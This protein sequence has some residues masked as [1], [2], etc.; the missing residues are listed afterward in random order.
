MRNQYDIIISGAGMVG[1]TLACALG[2]SGL[3]V[4]VIDRCDACFRYTSPPGQAL[5]A[6]HRDID[7]CALLPHAPLNPTL[8]QLKVYES[9]APRADDP[10]F[11]INGDQPIDV[12]NDQIDDLV[13]DTLVGEAVGVLDRPVGINDQDVLRTDMRANPPGLEL[14]RFAFEQLAVVIGGWRE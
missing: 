4:A 14:P 8:E 6:Q 7:L 3:K 5:G 9:L 12:G 10:A 13:P 11:G 2:A 1:S